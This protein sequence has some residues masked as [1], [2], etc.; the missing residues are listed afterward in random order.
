MKKNRQEA[1]LK[2]IKSECITTQGD[3]ME[4]LIEEGY[5]V[6]QATVSRD[7]KNLRIVKKQDEFGRT[8]YV[9]DASDSGELS[10]K[11][12]SVFVHS[13]C[14]VD[15][16]GHTVVIKCYTGMANA[17]CA[18]FDSMQIDGIVGTLAGDDTIFVLC[19]TPEIAENTKKII[20]DIIR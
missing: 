3:L 12:K 17:A 1:L 5:D 20:T 18:A 8:R 13:V 19:K 10:G 14:A 6:T 11:Y 7:I 4:R 2:I 15:F 9:A 16:A